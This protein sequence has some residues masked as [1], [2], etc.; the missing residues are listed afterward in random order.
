[1]VKSVFKDLK[2]TAGNHFL[3]NFYATVFM[4]LGNLQ[5]LGGNGGQSLESILERYSFLGAYLHAMQEYIP[6]DLAWQDGVDWMRDQ[7]V[8]WEAPLNRRLPL[9]AMQR[10]PGVSFAHRIGLVCAGLVEEDS[11]FGVLFDDLQQ[12]LS[13]QRPT[14]DLIG[15]LIQFVDPA[16][17]NSPGDAC[18][19]L[20]ATG[21][22]VPADRSTPF[23]RWQVHVPG[24]IW[25]VARQGADARLADWCRFQDRRAATRLK[26]LIF[27]QAFI[28]RLRNLPRMIRQE[29]VRLVL[30]RGPR[31]SERRTVLAA[32]FRMLRR[33]LIEVT[34]T[35]GDEEMLLLGPLCTMLGA[36]PIWVA[37]L[38][39][40]ESL[41]LPELTAYRG[42]LG[43][44][45]GLEGGL[46]KHLAGRVISLTL[47][48]L[49]VA[50][51]RR[52][53]Q[54]ALAGHP[55]DALDA[56]SARFLIPGAHIRQAAQGAIAH[57]ALDRRQRVGLEDVRSARRDL[58]HQALDSL[59]THLE[60]SGGWE[61]LI[62][63]ESV[64]RRLHELER[65]CRH[66]ETLLEHL[67]EAF[68]TQANR[69]VRALFNGSS[70]TGKTLAA[71]LLS[72]VLGMDLYRVDLAAVINKYVGETEK[73]LHRVLA[74]AEELD[75][76]LLLDEGDALMSKRTDVQS[77][78]DRYANL[79]TN[80]LLQRLETHEGIVLVTTNAGEYIDQ[81]FQRRMDVLV[82]FPIPAAHH[83][84]QIWRL[85]LPARHRVGDAKLTALAARCVL[86]GGQIR[87]AAQLATLMAVDSL[88]GRL[89][90]AHLEAAIEE[91]YRK[92]G[93]LSPMQVGPRPLQSPDAGL[94]AFVET[95]ST[96]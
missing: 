25:R 89:N 41:T 48:S 67:G 18:Q 92:A 8:A 17:A 52:H 46:D 93:A 80:Y 2:R 83:R 95:L 10:I 77:A 38:G 19:S 86:N 78:N 74:R 72:N 82:H 91:E 24:L 36:V 9:V 58:H 60:T 34:E 84:E 20:L 3:V 69:G 71:R 35:A 43:L 49:G 45:L 26:E 32:V 79:E 65:R 14:V 88:D 28:T 55:I 90:E 70:G 5:R 81:A 44:V 57:A 47:P 63:R 11:R 4:L 76:I 27:P 68:A 16:S 50:E 30:L 64:S 7:V 59:A 21:L 33:H 40:G 42:P 61:R 37:E 56:I 13:G 87:N 94:S 15:R 75:V 51:R 39:P 6:P 62:V 66:R 12:P 73:N 23:V 1:M 29:Q 85:H 96:E 31:G 22:L 54:Q 53:W